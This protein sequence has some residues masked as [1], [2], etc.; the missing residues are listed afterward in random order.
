MNGFFFLQESK[1]AM[2]ISKCFPMEEFIAFGE[3]LWMRQKKK[4]NF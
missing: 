3:L 4:A 1:R 2:L